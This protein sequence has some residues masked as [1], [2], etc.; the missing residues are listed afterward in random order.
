MDMGCWRVA[1]LSYINN[2][3]WEHLRHQGTENFRT[4]EEPCTTEDN[5]KYEN[6]SG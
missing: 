3:K 1:I 4:F 6:K 5:K 2:K